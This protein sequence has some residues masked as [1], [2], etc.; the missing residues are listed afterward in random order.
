MNDPQPDLALRLLEIIPAVMRTVAAE[1]RRSGHLLNPTHFNVLIT[2]AYGPCI[3]SDLAE[4]QAVSPPTM[5]NTVSTLVERGWVQRQRDAHDRRKV[6]LTL[7]PGGLQI[8]DTMRQQAEIRVNQP[9]PPPRPP[10]PPPPPPSLSHSPM[11]S[12]T[13]W[14]RV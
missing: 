9:P 7:T 1:L 12:G 4:Q 8:L 5:S 10:A 3:L 13:P 11:Q 6:W 2:L 14:P